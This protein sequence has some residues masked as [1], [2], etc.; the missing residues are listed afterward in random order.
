MVLLCFFSKPPGIGK[1]V[2][3][4]YFLYDSHTCHEFSTHPHTQVPKLITFNPYLCPE[5]VGSKSKKKYKWIVKYLQ[6]CLKAI[7]L[8]LKNYISSQTYVLYTYTISVL[9]LFWDTISRC[10]FL[11]QKSHPLKWVSV[12]LSP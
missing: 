8:L 3:K 2:R 10:E 6:E 4:N 12:Q 1:F 11:L 7:K 9:F 5:T